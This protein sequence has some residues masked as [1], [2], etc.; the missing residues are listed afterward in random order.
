MKE[1]E[2]LPLGL[3]GSGR[4][5]ALAMVDRRFGS[6]SII[7]VDVSNDA[8][9]AEV[10]YDRFGARVIGLH[11]TNHGDGMDFEWRQVKH[12]RILVYKIGRSYL[13]DLL[14][15][16]FQNEVVRMCP[17]QASLR[18]YEQLMNL[19]IE[20]KQSGITYGC[21]SG[22]HDDLAISCAMLAWATQHPH[23]PRWCWAL[24]GPPPARAKRFA[25][26]ALGWT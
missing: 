20:Y 22:Q 7:V 14:L 3:Y 13:F 17:G 21:P 12:S 25:P 5:D 11:I 2:E 19:E 18:A 16:E 1:F 10:M 4:A 26:S 24:Q 6:R 9:Y 23:L 15:R 8:T